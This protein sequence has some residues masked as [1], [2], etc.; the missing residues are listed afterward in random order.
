MSSAALCIRAAKGTLLTSDEQ[1][2]VFVGVMSDQLPVAE[3]FII[4]RLDARNLLVKS[5]AVLRIKAALG[6]RLAKTTFDEEDGGA[7]KS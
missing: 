5:E 4:R 1:T 3:R 6:A 7:E 2:I